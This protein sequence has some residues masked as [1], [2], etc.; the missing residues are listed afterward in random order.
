MPCSTPSAPVIFP[1]HPSQTGWR[2]RDGE[3]PDF[4]R[5]PSQLREPRIESFRPP[6]VTRAMGRCGVVRTVPVEYF[7]WVVGLRVQVQPITCL[8][9]MVI[10]NE[11]GLCLLP[12]WVRHCSAH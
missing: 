3:E 2:R 6:P 11:E 4:I 5:D 12:L 8:I 1:R 9:D 10:D 7:S